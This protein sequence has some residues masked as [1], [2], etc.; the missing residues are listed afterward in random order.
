MTP[1]ALSQQIAQLGVAV[2]NEQQ[3]TKLSR[4]K[5]VNS[6]SAHRY[7]AA[8]YKK[9]WQEKVERIGNLNYPE[10][11]RQKGFSGKLRMD[12]GIKHDG[13]IYSIRIR[14]SSG[15]KALDDAAIRIVRIGAPYA[16][17][18]K[19]LRAELDVLVISRIWRFSDKSGFQ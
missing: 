6:V 12:V 17:L 8:Y 4:I 14:K 1:E 13:S 10:V 19:E 2:R 15:Y 16:P 11:A 9:Q 5:F 3:D 18:P 7:K